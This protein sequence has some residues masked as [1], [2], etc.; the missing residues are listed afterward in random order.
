MLKVAA[1]LGYPMPVINF[2][3]SDFAR[4]S[5]LDLSQDE[6][7]EL[8]PLIGADVDRV[9][10]EELSVEF[11]P[12]RPDLYS[13]E[14]VARA[15]RAFTGNRPGLQD[16]PVAPATMELRVEPPVVGVRPWV[17]C[18]AVRGVELDDDAII[19]M[20]EL[21]E[22]LHLTLG[23][24]RSKVSIGVHDLDPL[25]PPFR[26]TAAHPNA[27]SFVPLQETQEMDLAR[28]LAEHPKGIDYAHLMEGFDRYPVIF[29]A[30]DQV[31]SFPPIINGT[32]TTVSESTSN[33]LLDVTG[34]DL[35][36]VTQALNI[37][38][39]A[40]AERGGAIEAVR[41]V[42]PKDPLLGP[43]SGQTLVTPDLTPQTWS[44]E[45]DY[46][47][48]LLGWE[49]APETLRQAFLRMGLDASLPDEGKGPS[50]LEV[51]VPAYRW[52]I[53]HRVD[54][55]EEAAIGLGYLNARET[56]P[57]S[58]TFGSRRAAQERAEAGREV[59]VSLGFQE[60]M[61]LS[62]S[63]GTAQ[64]EKMGQGFRGS[65]GEKLDETAEAGAT[66][67][68]A[69]TVTSGERFPEVTRLANPIGAE[70]TLLRTSLV[71]GLLEVLASNTHRELPQRLFEVGEVVLDHSNH[72]R[73][74]FVELASRASFSRAKG[75][76][77]ALLARL[78]LDGELRMEAERQPGF[79][80]GRCARVYADGRP[81]G[82][83]GEIA[84]STII[85]WELAHPLIAGEFEL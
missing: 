25:T 44:V 23:R 64:F 57:G 16:Y 7:L 80:P 67:M 59:L 36:A 61:T 81:L 35:P 65:D 13:V 15:M 37:V 55:V 45:V 52:D 6:F 11:F 49:S 33:I 4:L 1:T 77:E 34:L 18:G 31:L 60:A 84:P 51:R 10:G 71:P 2:Y 5:G 27:V 29:D 73:M 17:V 32:L 76:S 12:N 42:Y 72:Q 26:Y 39:C 62:L 68:K 3:F 78:G 14:G 30:N 58:M 40:L 24:K 82:H 9:E 70:Y 63:G 8:V 47:D 74:A 19:A 20:M 48:G 56:L 46:L 41:V 38:A 28:I 69:T 54:L 79:I 66:G 21:Q 43:T 85:A 22:K 83:F 50:T 53:L 75:L